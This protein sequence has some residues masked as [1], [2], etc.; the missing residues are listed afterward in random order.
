[1]KKIKAQWNGMIP[2]EL[3]KRPCQFNINSI[4]KI[5]NTKRKSSNAYLIIFPLKIQDKKKERERNYT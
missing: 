2:Y 5:K 4:I 3:K 1:M